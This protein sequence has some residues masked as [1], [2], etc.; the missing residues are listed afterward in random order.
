MGF[1]ELPVNAG[2]VR[3][4]QNTVLRYSLPIEIGKDNVF[5]RSEKKPILFFAPAANQHVLAVAAARAHVTGGFLEQ[6]ELGENLARQGD[7]FC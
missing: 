3:R 2:F 1:I 7:L 4:L 5:C 6:S